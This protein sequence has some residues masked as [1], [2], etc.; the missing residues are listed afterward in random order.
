MGVCSEDCQVVEEAPCHTSLIS[1]H[2][3]VVNEANGQR[4]ELLTGGQLSHS[5]HL[6][7]ND[8]CTDRRQMYVPVNIVD[9]AHG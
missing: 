5:G 8:Q 4:L 1:S 7:P 2:P 9:N 3:Q 6:L